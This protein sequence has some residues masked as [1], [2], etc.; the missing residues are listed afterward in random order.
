MT[1][2]I[3]QLTRD[4]ESYTAIIVAS[5]FAATYAWGRSDCCKKRPSKIGRAGGVNLAVD[6]RHLHLASERPA[7]VPRV[8]RSMSQVERVGWELPVRACV[9]A[10]MRAQV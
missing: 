8:N 2:T 3:M 4:F 10:R 6:E 5:T 9:R 1:R 7:R